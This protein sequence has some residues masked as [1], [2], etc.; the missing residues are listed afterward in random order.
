[1]ADEWIPW[2][3]RTDCLEYA[4]EIELPDYFSPFCLFLG[5]IPPDRLE[6]IKA[7]FCLWYA[8]KGGNNVQY[9]EQDVEWVDGPPVTRFEFKP[10]VELD[11]DMQVHIR[12]QTLILAE[13]ETNNDIQEIMESIEAADREIFKA[14]RLRKREESAKTRWED[15][16]NTSPDEI[17]TRRSEMVR[18]GLDYVGIS[19]WER[20]NCKINPSREIVTETGKNVS[21]APDSIR[22]FMN[23]RRSREKRK[24]KRAGES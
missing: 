12:K 20:D 16:P 10:F 9:G 5:V 1:M 13:I 17:Y 23:Q 11:R 2:K 24:A 6:E 14:E 3:D 7:R 18:A 19:E 8:A 21:V 15:Y 4:A 22:C